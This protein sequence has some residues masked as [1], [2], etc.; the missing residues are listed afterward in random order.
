MSGL[1]SANTY[2]RCV[3]VTGGNYW[4]TFDCNMPQKFVCQSW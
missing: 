4:M 2:Q 3:I 1:L